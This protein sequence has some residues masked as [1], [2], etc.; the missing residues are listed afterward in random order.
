MYS[1]KKITSNPTVDFAA[2]E[3]KKYLRMMMP[4]CGEI[5]ISFAPEAK[6]GFRLGLMEDFGLDLS[7]AQDIHLDDIVHIDTDENGGIIAGSN[8]R[9]ILFAVYKLLYENGCR[10]LYPGIDGEYIPLCNIK[11]VKYHK[12]ADHRYRGWCNEG[13]EA[14]YNMIETIDFAPKLGMNVYMLEFD[15]PFNYYDKYYS[16]QFNPAKRP[17]KITLETALQWKRQCEA[18]ISK[19]G[20]QYHDMG[21]GWTAEPFG[22]DSSK[23]WVKDHDIAVA[24]ETAKHLA[25][26][27]GVRGFYKAMPL[28]TNVCMSNP[29]TRKIIA[30]YIADYAQVQNNVDFLHVW[31]ADSNNNHCECINCASKNPSDW[32]IELLNDI[33]AELEDRNLPTHLVFIVYMDT[34]WAPLYEKLHNH[35]RFTMLFA[36]C[37]R[38]YTETYG[39][40]PDLNKISP[41][42][43]NKIT[44]PKG[45]AENLAYLNE[46]KKTYSGDCFCYEYYFWR[47][48]YYDPGYQHLPKLIYDDIRALKQCGLSGIVADGTQRCFF[49]NGFAL[50]VYG[51]A[52]FD[53]S[54][55]Y[56]ALL[57]DYFTHT[58]GRNWKK[59]LDYLN[60]IT[61][62]F[63]FRYLC[64]ELSS[65]PEKGKWYNPEHAKQLE[66]IE[67]I[68]DSFMPVVTENIEQPNRPASVSWQLL[69]YHGKYCKLLA[70]ACIQ[71]ALGND[72]KALELENDLLMQMGVHE[73]A[74]Q[75][76]YDQGL[77][78]SSLRLIFN[79]KPI[80]NVMI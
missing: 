64:G 46:W 40:M 39:M 45:M 26:I 21:H 76:Y 41:Y 65:D 19:R 63:D 56:D 2:E 50:Y 54:I 9:S 27:N 58:Y 69:E 67:G 14:Q 77:I 35:S 16:H 8:P 33:D 60:S 52:L 11:G 18:E 23:G 68:V 15:I 30:K 79:I 5:P 62:T 55:D 20:L 61:K 47:K 6:D 29:E 31:L 57:E 73:D 1:I 34:L 43:R 72:E 42:V 59:V 38:L 78:G 28:T 80:T 53:S 22:I 44:L 17:E 66:R 48:T 70:K 4:R 24:P 32:Y 74:I 12:M 71:K 7:E 10:W 51:M 49:P 75:R 25:M 3:L 13:S 36:P 37:S